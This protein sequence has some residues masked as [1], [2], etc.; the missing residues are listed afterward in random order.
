MNQLQDLIA[1]HCDQSGDTLA[2]IAAR[3]Q[4]SRQT[5]SNLMNREGL[6]RVPHAKTLRGLATGMGLPLDTVAR[7]AAAAVY[8]NE[9]ASQRNVVT[10]LVSLAESMTDSQVTVLCATARAMITADADTP[11]P[12]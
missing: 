10:V 4:L 9:R 6:T 7:V 8:G 5:V 12:V 2:D 11:G 3:G 1:Q